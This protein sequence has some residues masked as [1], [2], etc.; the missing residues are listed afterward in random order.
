MAESLWK[1][2]RRS[3]TVYSSGEKYTKIRVDNARS[4]E[5]HLHHAIENI[6]R[7]FHFNVRAWTQRNNVISSLVRN[8]NIL[9]FIFQSK[10]T[11]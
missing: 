9:F 7:E 2:I 4:F 10:S 5:D 3:Q 8:D 6:S 11:F 1:Y